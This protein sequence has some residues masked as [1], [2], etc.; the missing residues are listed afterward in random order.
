[1]GFCINIAK[2]NIYLDTA[3]AEIKNQC[4]DFLSEEKDIAFTA[5]AKNK[6]DVDTE[7]IY[8][9]EDIAEKLI[10]F[11]RMVVHGALIKL[12]NQGILLMGLPSSGKTTRAKYLAKTKG[13]EIINGDKPI[14]IFEKDGIYACGTPWAGKENIYKNEIIKLSSCIFVERNQKKN[15]IDL[16]DDKALELLLRE[17]YLPKNMPKCMSLCAQMVRNLNFKKW[18]EELQIEN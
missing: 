3:S 6:Q 4:N 9:Y 8:L 1:M 11:D 14:L 2:L 15:I 16:P 5:S 18:S 13:A 7:F 12:A 10:N 17:V